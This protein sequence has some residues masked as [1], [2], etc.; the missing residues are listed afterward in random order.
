MR[1]CVLQHLAFEDLGTFAPVLLETGWTIQACHVADGLPDARDWRDAD[2]CIVLGG[3]MGVH[4]GAAYPFL[5]REL[6]LVR[7]RL[8][9]GRPLPGKAKEIGWGGLQLTEAGAA[10]PLAA[11][12]GAPVLHW[13]GDTFDLPPAATL[14]AST[15]ITLHQAFQAGAGQLALQFHAEADAARMEHWLMGHACELAA[16]GLD[17]AAIRQ[18]ARDLGSRAAA[19][20]QDFFRRWLTGVFTA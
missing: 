13:H 16:A 17:V 18:D 20:G 12:R 3:P 9:E 2:L 5:S 1:C 19:A 11:L 4:D 7:S 8:G 10:S 15:D 14:L 6:E